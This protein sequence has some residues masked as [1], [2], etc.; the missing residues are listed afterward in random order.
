MRYQLDEH[1]MHTTEGWHR[2]Q[3]INNWLLSLGETRP[4]GIDDVTRY[5]PFVTYTIF[6]KPKKA[7]YWQLGRKKV[8]RWCGF[9]PGPGILRK[10]PS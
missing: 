10:N 1:D 6:L 9:G 7:D 3:R 8:T 5:G 2:L 4:I